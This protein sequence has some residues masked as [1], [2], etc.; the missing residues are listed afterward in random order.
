M[1]SVGAI[2]PGYTEPPNSGF[3]AVSFLFFKCG[4]PWPVIFKFIKQ[5]QHNFT[6]SKCEND[7]S[8]IPVTSL[9]IVVLLLHLFTTKKSQS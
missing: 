4:I 5:Q 7:P 6:E 8:N 3:V 2:L 9:E 1:V